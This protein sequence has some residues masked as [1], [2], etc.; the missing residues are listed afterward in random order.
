MLKLV[1][2]CEAMQLEA[3]HVPREFV[4]NNFINGLKDRDLPDTLSK[5]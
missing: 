3:S 2:F 4:L 5:Y 1:H